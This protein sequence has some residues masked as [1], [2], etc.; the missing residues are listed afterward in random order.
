MDGLKKFDSEHYDVPASNLC[1]L[2]RSLRMSNFR[3]E[4]S[5]TRIS[6]QNLKL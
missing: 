5:S 2:D 6:V 4:A 3:F 1:I